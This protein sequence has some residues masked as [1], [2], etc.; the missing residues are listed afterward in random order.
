MTRHSFISYIWEH[1]LSLLAGLI[2]L[3]IDAYLD[4][5]T[6]ALYKS[7][8]NKA[9]PEGNMDAAMARSWNLIGIVTVLAGTQLAASFMF[10]KVGEGVSARLR[11]QMFDALHQMPFGYVQKIEIHHYDKLRGLIRV[12]HGV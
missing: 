11:C 2:I 3:A 5:L 9:L 10:S 6:P 4:S 1:K 8:V 12:V 7:I